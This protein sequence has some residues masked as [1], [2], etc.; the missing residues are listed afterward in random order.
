M[1][2]AVAACLFVCSYP[3]REHTGFD[4]YSFIRHLRNSG[5]ELSG[6]I[7][8]YRTLLVLSGTDPK[9]HPE[10]GEIWETMPSA[11]FSSTRW[12][13]EQGLDVNETDDAGMT[14]LMLSVKNFDCDAEFARMT[15]YTVF[16]LCLLKADASIRCPKSGFQALHFLLMTNKRS[17]KS[18]P[19]LMEIAYILI[20]FG[21]ADVSAETFNGLSV[22][23]IALFSGWWEELE[24]VLNRCGLDLWDVF[25]KEFQR[26]ARYRGGSLGDSTAVDTDEISEP[27][28]TV[29]K[30]KAAHGDRLI[31]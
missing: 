5:F 31:D 24:M 10:Q 3:R 14:P 27:C 12:L 18:A 1:N 19:T 17:A 9:L 23:S 29:T 11:L 21:G 16:C 15:P 20:H 30:R 4:F 2:I 13:V 8:T 7:N 26:S 28:G 6:N 22:S 25:M